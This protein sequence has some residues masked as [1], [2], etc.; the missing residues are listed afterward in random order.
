M[1]K[2]SAGILTHLAMLAA[3]L[4]L[5]GAALWVSPRDRADIIFFGAGLAVVALFI[6]M[7]FVRHERWEQINA[8]R[9]KAHTDKSLADALRMGNEL[10]QRFIEAMQ[11]QDSSFNGAMQAIRNNTLRIEESERKIAEAHGRVDAVDRRLVHVEDHLCIRRDLKP[12]GSD[13]A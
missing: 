6:S 13:P 3:I 5:G 12:Y 1:T 8:E 10:T 7:R 2:E 4:V 9:I 11:V